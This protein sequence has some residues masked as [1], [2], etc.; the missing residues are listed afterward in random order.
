MINI[1]LVGKIYNVGNDQVEALKNINLQIA[2]GEFIAIVGPSGS[3][4]ST[5]LHLI[6]GLDKITSGKIQVNGKNLNDLNDNQLSHYRNREIGFVFQDFHMQSHLNIMEN[7]KIPLI[8]SQTKQWKHHNAKK[9]TIDIM[10]AFGLYERLKHKPSQISGGQK[11][12][13]AIARALVNR[14]KILLADE[15]T[16]NLDSLTGKK[17]IALLKKIHQ[18]QKITVLVV[19]HD[20]E[21]AKYAD[22]MIEIKDGRLIQKDRFEK[23]TG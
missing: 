5:L 10:V 16:G 9:K 6:G 14:P 13:V 23:F 22:R 12:R 19:T 7:I 3:G 11:Q 15:P 2:D 8:F 18:V 20:R 21:I 17:I 4:K 1:E